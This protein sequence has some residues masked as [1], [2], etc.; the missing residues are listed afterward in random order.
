[1]SRSLLTQKDIQKA[2]KFTKKELDFINRVVSESW[3]KE[4]RPFVY[5]A[6]AS[7]LL[8]CVIRGSEGVLSK[9]LVVD[10]ADKGI[11]V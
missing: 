2:A 4:H 9:K 8:G 1:M 6:I 3:G 7:H 11:E 10:L 5:I